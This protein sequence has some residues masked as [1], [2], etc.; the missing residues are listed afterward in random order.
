M[1]KIKLLILLPFLFLTIA[2]IQV[3]VFEGAEKVVNTHEK[4]YY[5]IEDFESVK[6][7]DIH[8][9]I[10]TEEVFFI[11]QAQADNFQ[12]LDIVDD[13]PFGLPMDEQQ[14][15][16]MLHLKN[17]SKSMAIATTFPVKDWGMMTGV[18][19]Q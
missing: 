16:A 14:K 10:N 15:V 17:F 5:G 12:F 18:K 11:E 1:K 7:F 13:R 4:Q 8:I 9:H 6:K 19:T 3:Q 2:F